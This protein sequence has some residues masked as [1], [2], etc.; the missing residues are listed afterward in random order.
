MNARFFT[1]VVLVALA[2]TLQTSQA[3]PIYTLSTVYNGSSGTPPTGSSVT[4]SF[5]DGVPGQVYLTIDFDQGAGNTGFS[6]TSIGFNFASSVANTYNNTLT[7]TVA[8]HIGG[9][10]TT[11]VVHQYPVSYDAGM[12]GG[13]YCVYIDTFNQTFVSGD[14][15]TFAFT[16]SV[17]GLAAADFLGLSSTSQGSYHAD[18]YYAS[19][20]IYHPGGPYYN[21]G[22]TTSVPEP[23]P[24]ML[25]M[26]GLMGLF[27]VQRCKK[28]Q[29]QAVALAGK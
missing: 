8:G 1:P 12:G 11:P 16:S 23:G 28:S 10:S 15:I 5:K 7:S 24:A 14:E 4:A 27:V 21:L 29:I 18:T 20:V 3:V 13:Y 22:A 25:G 17:A 26:L 19:A 2:V 6:L 9:V